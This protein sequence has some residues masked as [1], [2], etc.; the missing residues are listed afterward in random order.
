MALDA[1]SVIVNF[2]Q[3]K[4]KCCKC[5]F[6][7]HFHNCC[8]TGANKQNVID[9]HLKLLLLYWCT[10]ARNPKSKPDEEIDNIFYLDDDDFI[11]CT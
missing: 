7:D 3:R 9:I 5:V 2:G 10:A 8:R 1:I 11:T 6:P 4:N